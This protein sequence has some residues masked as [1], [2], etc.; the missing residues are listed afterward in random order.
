MEKKKAIFLTHPDQL[1]SEITGGVQLCSQ[2]FHHII[3][4]MEDISLQ[5][6]FVS[7]TKNIPQRIRIKLGLE[8]YSTYHINKDSPALLEYIVSHG[9]E[10]IFINMASA[11][12]YAKPVK[13]Q[14][15]DKVKI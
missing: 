12:R 10:L 4:N 11:V 9:V 7:Y 8:N 14:F 1:R 15:G 13:E 3:E 6:Y 5:D 2:E